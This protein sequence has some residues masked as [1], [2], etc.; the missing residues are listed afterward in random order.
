MRLIGSVLSLA[1]LAGGGWWLW[2]NNP[3]VRQFVNHHVDTGNFQTLEIR[4]TPSQLMEANRSELL[5]GENY[6]FLEPTILFHSYLMMEVKY[7]DDNSATRESTLI[8]G[9]ENGEMVLSTSSW[10]TTHGFEDCINAHADRND[11]KVINMLAKRGGIMER[12]SLAKH[13]YVEQDILDQ[14]LDSCRKKHLV[15]L[16]GTSCRLH[17]QQPLLSLHPETKIRESLVVKPYEGA[18]RVPK[19]YSASQ[20]ERI[21]Q[22]AYGADFAIRRTTEIY[23]PVIRIDVKNPDDS[24]LVTYWNGVTGKR[25]M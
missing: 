14:W 2:N 5:R 8:W 13:L 3:D 12:D 25:I 6:N 21:A 22:A 9:L 10:E 15:V 4:Y 11:F 1:L 17:L 23:L 18:T 19:K 20:I 7:T 16:S 24:T